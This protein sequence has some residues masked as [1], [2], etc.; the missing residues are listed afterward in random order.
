MAVDSIVTPFLLIEWI[1][2]NVNILISD[3]EDTYK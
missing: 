2:Y 1:V 3:T